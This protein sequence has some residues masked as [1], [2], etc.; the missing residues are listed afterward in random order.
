MTATVV[1]PTFKRPDSLIA[2]LEG[3]VAQT[4][5]PDQ[6]VVVARP[7]DKA[8]LQAIAGSN[9][10]VDLA[11]IDRPG[12]ACALN[13]GVASSVGDVVA[14]TDDDAVPRPDWLERALSHFV[15]PSVGGVGGRDVIPGIDAPPDAGELRVGWIGPDGRAYGNH[16]LA[17]GKPRRVMW[18]KGVNMSYRRE[19]CEFDESLR[20]SGAQFANDLDVSLR[21]SAAGWS[22]VYD[23]SVTVDHYPGPRFDSDGRER[24]SPD[25]LKNAA[26][27]EMLSFLRWL[28]AG[29]RIRTCGYLWTVGAG[30][31]A[32]PLGA[33][34][35]VR[36]APNKRDLLVATYYC[37]LGRSEAIW[38]WCTGRFRRAAARP[39]ELELAA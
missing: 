33:V 5:V 38:L 23:P 36:N 27:N 17:E 31:K 21:V 18:L 34:A 8:T 15:D 30:P 2:C 37:T 26:F 12:Q 22:L 35:K 13:A 25:A 1:V 39:M 14:F 20:G 16:H 4:R 19:L 29:P 28:P 11:M 6:I 10:E 24:Q 9:F 7:E 32:G 3:L